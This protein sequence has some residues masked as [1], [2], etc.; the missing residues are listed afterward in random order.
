MIAR[1][2]T[3][4]AALLVRLLLAGAVVALLISYV[5]AVHAAR[6]AHVRACKAELAALKAN[7]F[8]DKFVTPS[9]PCLA[10]QIVRE[11]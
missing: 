2:L 6:A 7:A 5:S 9:D 4:S 10:I 11:R 3:P 1:I 8:V